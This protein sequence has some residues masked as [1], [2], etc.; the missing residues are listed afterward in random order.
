MARSFP[1]GNTDTDKVVVSSYSDIE[2][3]STL[4]VGLWVARAGEGGNSSGRMVDKGNAFQ[5]YNLSPTYRFFAL[6]WATT[7]GEWSIPRPSAT[8]FH[9]LLWTYSYSSTTNDPVCYVDGILQSVTEV[10]TPVG[11]ATDSDVGQ[12]V[13]I[14]NI[15]DARCWNGSLD[16]IAIWNRI[17]T[18]DEA[19]FLWA[20]KASSAQDDDSLATGLVF[21][22]PL[23]IGSPE[24]NEFAGGNTGTVTGTSAVAGPTLFNSDAGG[25]A[26]AFPGLGGMIVR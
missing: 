4:S 16:H 14:G 19:R 11:T 23:G 13:T 9:H 26:G 21:Y 5:L 24:P 1:G 10:A 2:S 7:N 6:K 17:L 22:M 8:V 25:G 18:A 3:L 15:I 20:V 12:A